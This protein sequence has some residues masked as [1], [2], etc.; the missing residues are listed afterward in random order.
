MQVNAKISRV[1]GKGKG[2]DAEPTF[3]MPSIPATG[4]R[5]QCSP[6]RPSNANRFTIMH[7]DTPHHI[8]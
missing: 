7:R 1:K 4:V 5:R 6:I 3:K 2:P 8:P